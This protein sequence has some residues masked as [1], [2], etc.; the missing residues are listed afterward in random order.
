MY[1]YCTCTGAILSRSI[2]NIRMTAH[3]IRSR[4]T[5]HFTHSTLNT[6][7][8][9]SKWQ[10]V[11]CSCNSWC[12]WIYMYTRMLQIVINK[13][14]VQKCTRVWSHQQHSKFVKYMYTLFSLSIHVDRTWRQIGMKS[15]LNHNNINQCILVC[16]EK[17]D[18]VHVYSTIL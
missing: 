1:I 6:E 13:L 12:M 15:L 8:T 9:Q 16:M 17:Y 5:L 7:H 2:P 3:F 10:Y 11:A 18:Y 14:D 4:S